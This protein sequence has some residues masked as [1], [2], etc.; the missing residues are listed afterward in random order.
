MDY[1]ILIGRENELKA[2]GDS[3]DNKR[4]II[5]FGQEGVGKTAIISQILKNRSMGKVLLSENSP[6]L[7][8]SLENIIISSGDYKGDIRVKNILSLKKIL[9]A[10]LDKSPEYLVFDHVGRVDPKFYSFLTYLI[11][12][13]IPLLIVC[14]G[15]DKKDISH[16]RLSLF[17]FEKMAV[18]NLDK[19]KTFALVN[20]Y[21]EIFG[22]KLTKEDNFKKEIFHFSKGNPKIIKKLCFLAHDGKYRRDDS[23]DVHLIDLDMRIGDVVSKIDKNFVKE[24][25]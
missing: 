12:R 15:V 19:E 14:R 16:L 18:P 2:I 17:A 4:N 20:R 25:L 5:V 24:D 9:Y 23:L 6:S 11:D 21:I 3:I 13:K 8:E 1:D 7:K 22:I 10:L